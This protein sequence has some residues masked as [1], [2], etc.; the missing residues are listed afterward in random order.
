MHVVMRQDF[1]PRIS[2]HAEF[3]VALPDVGGNA[4]S[5]LGCRHVVIKFLATRDC[6]PQRRYGLTRRLDDF[7]NRINESP[8]VSWLM[9]FDRRT[10]RSYDVRGVALF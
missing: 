2:F 9:S 5:D 4:V 3:E 10:Y 1:V 6:A 8:V 7:R